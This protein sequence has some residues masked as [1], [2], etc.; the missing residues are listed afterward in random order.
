MIA[1]ESTTVPSRSKQDDRK[2]HRRP[3]VALGQYVDAR[4]GRG[5]RAARSCP[6]SA[7]GAPSSSARELVRLALEHR[8]DERPHHVPQERVG[9]DLEAR[10]V[11]ALVPARAP[12]PRARRRRAASRC[13]VNARKS[14][15][16][17]SS[18]A[19][20]F[21]RST[22]SGRGYHQRAAHLERRALAPA[23]DPVAI[24]R[25]G[26]E[27]RAWKSGAAS[28]AGDD[29]DVVGQHRVQRLGRA[30]D[31]RAAAR[32]RPR[33]RCASACTP[34]S[35]RPATASPPRTRRPR[36]RVR[37]SPS[38]VR[39]PGCR[40]SRGSRCRRTRASASGASGIPP[41]ACKAFL[42]L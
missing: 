12:R 33:R 3:I 16:P 5:P 8:A 42:M 30:L 10:G 26:R 29:R 1:P 40:P 37:S 22:S 19:A 6:A 2:P 31:R 41:A 9:G 7:R 14:C 38:T 13:G 4:R 11:A 36:E 35:V 32:R 28:S 39:S 15:S 25:D 27:K 24:V 18:A 20:S 34:V 23:P 21:R 17:T